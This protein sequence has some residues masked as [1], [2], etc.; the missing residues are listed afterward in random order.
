MATQVQ[1][2]KE[3]V[4]K[5]V[6]A[7]T[8]T[9]NYDWLQR[10]TPEALDWMWARDAE[11]QAATE[12]TGLLAALE[13]GIAAELSGGTASASSPPRLL[14]GRWFR[15][16]PGLQSA[17]N[18][19]W[20]SDRVDA[21]GRVLV[22]SAALAG[23]D[24]NAASTNFFFYEPAPNGEFVIFAV[25]SGG[26]MVG[27]WRIVEVASGRVL[28]LVVPCVAYSGAVVGWL[29]DA[30]GFYL[31]DRVEDGRHRVCFHPV[32]PGTAPRPEH[33]FS[34][35]EI[36]AN[37]S[38]VTMQVS[39]DGKHAIGLAGPHERIAYVVGD[40]ARNAWRRFLPAHHEGECQGAWLD[41]KTYV[42]R[43]HDSDTPAGRVVAMPVASSGDPA[44]WREIAPASRAVIK[45][46]GLVR[47]RVV[48]AEVLDCAARFRVLDLDGRNERIVPL[49]GPGT[50]LIA[51]IWRR[52][53]ANEALTFSFGSF[54]QATTHYHFDVD[55]HVLTVIG[56]P[57]RRTDGLR[58]TQ[59][60]ARSIDGTAVPYFVVHR[61]DLDLS[62]PNPALLYGYGGFNAAMMPSPLAH[63]APFVQA[64]GIFIHANLRGGGEYGKHWHDSGRLA[65]KWNVFADLFAVAEEA[66][67]DGLTTPAQFAMTGASNGGLLAGVALVH[68][69]DLWR[70]V[71][72][73]VPIFDQMEPLPR[74]PQFDAVRAIFLEDYGSP[75]NLLMS[76]LL[77]SYSPYHNVKGGTAYP[78]VYQVFGEKDLSCMPYQGRKFTAALR[79]ASTSG[80]PVHLRVW[81]DTGHGSSSA[82]FSAGWMAF[83]MQQLGM[84]YPP[85]G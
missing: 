62:Q 50:S 49:Q 46:A 35:E 43:V 45:A 72:P 8:F 19:L 59:R 75:D 22:E 55:S 69:P 51:M 57:G 18:A 56:E 17:V 70:V 3:A 81:K 84:S 9:D 33:V 15:S 44:T 82:A 11:A 20:V 16:A 10:D 13:R 2:R 77:Y 64:G 53:D 60:F 79:A 21:P 1:A 67:R 29:P 52:F 61:E 32:K 4:T 24:D 5:T 80:H 28:D 65:A 39:P 68:R 12:A 41:G 25:T 85:Q 34:L 66:I 42:A 26:R 6:G 14:G 40:L 36:P 23:P 47:G 78:A 37:V 71:V 63:V 54:T 58:V 48:L 30:S 27:H 74:E 38:G 83:L 7:V 76:K 31:A 73:V